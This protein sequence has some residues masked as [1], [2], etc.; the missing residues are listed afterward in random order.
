LKILKSVQVG[1]RPRDAAFTPDSSAAYVS[2]E[3]DASLY[4]IAVPRGDP[5]ER[6]LQLRKEARPMSVVLDPKRSRLYLS[7]GRGGTVAVLNL[8]GLELIKEIEVGKRPWGLALSEDGR[9]LY[10]ANGPSNDVSIVDTGKLSVSKRVPVG[11]SPWGVVLGP[12]P[13]ASSP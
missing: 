2:G 9:L 13:P 10:S 3:F 7:T 1:K 6:V 8:D 4:R 5:V 11:R 12:T